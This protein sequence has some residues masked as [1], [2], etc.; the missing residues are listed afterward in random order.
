MK[1]SAYFFRRFFLLCLYFRKENIR[2]SAYSFRNSAAVFRKK[3]SFF[4][5]INVLVRTGPFIHPYY[6]AKN[7]R[8][9]LNGRCQVQLAF[10]KCALRIIYTQTKK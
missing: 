9:P 6:I 5:F 1:V 10:G 3:K 7:S 2:L 8:L 4:F